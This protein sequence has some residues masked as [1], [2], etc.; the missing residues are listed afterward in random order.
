MLHA[1]KQNFYKGGVH[2]CLKHKQLFQD[3]FRYLG[4]F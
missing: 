4:V 1:V 2:K 3:G